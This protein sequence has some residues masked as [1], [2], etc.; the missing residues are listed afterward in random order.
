MALDWEV[1]DRVSSGDKIIPILGIPGSEE[2]SLPPVHLSSRTL[3]MSC[4]I[5]HRVV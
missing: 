5:T 3:P 4:I 2:Q 1:N